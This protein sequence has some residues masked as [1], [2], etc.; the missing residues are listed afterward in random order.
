MNFPFRRSKPLIVGLLFAVSLIA[1]GASTISATA[2]TTGS[3][4][5]AQAVNSKGELVGIPTAMGVGVTETVAQIMSREH[6][7]PV[8]I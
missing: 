3:S 2:A 7:G 5:V 1:G 4:H 6:G 8:A